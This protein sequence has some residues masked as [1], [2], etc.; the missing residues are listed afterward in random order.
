MNFN[1][2]QKNERD[3]IFKQIIA[4]IKPIRKL[5]KFPTCKFKI[6]LPLKQVTQLTI[7]EYKPLQTKKDSSMIRSSLGLDKLKISQ[8][9]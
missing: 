5:V 8:M 2:A 7:V 9:Q 4:T 1:H 6:I 3:K